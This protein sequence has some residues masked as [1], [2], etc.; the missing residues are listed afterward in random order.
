MEISVSTIVFWAVTAAVCI[1]ILVVCKKFYNTFHDVVYVILRLFKMADE[2]PKQADPPP[3][4]VSGIESIVMPDIRRDFPEFDIQLAKDR[5]RQYLRSQ[6]GSKKGLQIHNLVLH[7]YVDESIQK[8]IIF[9]AAVSWREDRL[10]QK[11]YDI[12]YSYLLP[13]AGGG[14]TLNCP[15]C[16]A[17]IGFGERQCAYCGTQVLNGLQRN[18]EFTQINES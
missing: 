5:A 6:L 12:H 15:N 10:I 8:T 3:R 9:Q 4:T 2:M 16:G 1:L 11:R 13:E 14:L 17:V 7:R 18:W